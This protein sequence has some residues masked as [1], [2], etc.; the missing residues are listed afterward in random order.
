[1]SKTTVNLFQTIKEAIPT[2]IRTEF[3]LFGELLEQYYIGLE[4]KTGVYNI[5]NQIDSQIK[6]D[7][8]FSVSK[9]TKL[10]T[11]NFDF[12]TTISVESTEG[13]PERNGLIKI[14]DEIIFYK[15]KTETEFLDCYRGFSGVDSFGKSINFSET[16]AQDHAAGSTVNNLYSDLLQE[17]LFQIKKQILPGL[18]SSDIVANENIFLKQSVNFYNTKGS[19]ESFRILF[20]ALFGVSAEIIRPQENLIEPSKSYYNIT[21]DLLVEPIVGDVERCLNRTIFQESESGDLFYGT[22]TSVEKVNNLGREYYILSVDFNYDK[23]IINKGSLFGVFNYSQRTVVLEDVTVAPFISG[24]TIYVNSTLGFPNEGILQIKTPNE[25]LFDINYFGKNSNQFFVSPTEELLIPKKSYLTTKNFAFCNIEDERIQVRI[26]PLFSN[27]FSVDQN[28]LS[29]QENDPVVISSL[30]EN[31]LGDKFNNWVFNLR[32][33]ADVESISIEDDRLN[34]YRITFFNEYN[35]YLGDKFDLISSDGIFYELTLLTKNSNKVY[36]FS[37][38]NRIAN[39]TTPGFHAIR[40]ISKSKF[41]EEF[42]SS[43][44]TIANVQNIYTDLL[45]KDVYVETGSIPSYGEDNINL[46]SKRILFSGNYSTEV[47]NFTLNIGKN[48]LLTGEAVIYSESVVADLFDENGFFIGNG[49]NPNRLSIPNG[50]YFVKVVDSENIKL[51]VSLSKLFNDQFVSFS[52]SVTNNSLYYA[53]RDWLSDEFTADYIRF[54]DFLKIEHQKLIKRISE[55]VN[56]ETKVET[57]PGPIGIFKNGTELLNYK[58]LDSI[59]Y[60]SIKNIDVLTEGQEYDIINRPKLNIDDTSLGITYGSGAVGEVRLSGSLKRIEVLNPGVGFLTKPSIKISGGNGSGALA[61]PIFESNTYSADFNS[62]TSVSLATNEIIFENDSYFVTGEVVRYVSGVNTSLGGL[63]NNAS[64]FVR[65]T[66]SNKVKLYGNLEDCKR[67]INELNISSFGTGVHSLVAVKN[68]NLLVDFKVISEGSGYKSINLIFNSSAIN[69]YDDSINID[70]HQLKT[71]EIIVYNSDD[72]SLGGLS[73]GQKYYVYRVNESKI[74]LSLTEQDLNLRKF[75]NITSTGQGLHTIQYDPITVTVTNLDNNN[76]NTLNIRPIFKGFIEGVNVI[77]GG[78]EYGSR[79][80]INFNRQ[81]TISLETG[82]GCKLKPVILQGRIFAVVIENQGSGYNSVPDLQIIGDG[83]GAKILPVLNDG[84]VTDIIIQS[85]GSGYSKDTKIFVKSAGSGAEFFAQIDKWT[86]NLVEK[87]FLRRLVTDDD[88]FLSKG[89]FGLKYTYC[90]TPRKLREFTLTKRIE[91]GVERFVPDL[92]INLSDGKEENSRY[93]SPILGWAYDGNPIYGPYGF[94][95]PNGTGEIVRMKSGYNIAPKENRPGDELIF[96]L[97][98][99]V[100]DYEYSD[101]HDLDESNG[102]FCV[103]PEYPK[104][105]YA[106]FSTIGE[107]DPLYK[108]YRK[109]AFPYVIGNNYKSTPIDFNFDPNIHQDNVEVYSAL[110]KNT[111]PYNLFEENSGYEGIDVVELIQNHTSEI[112]TFSKGSVDFV[113][114]VSNGDNYKVNDRLLFDNT[115]TNS[116]GLSGFVKSLKGREIVSINQTLNSIEDVEIYK[117]RSGSVAICSSPHNIDDIGNYVYYFNEEEF[118]SVFYPDKFRLVLTENIENSST[119]GLTTYIN[120]SGLTNSYPFVFE[121]DVFELDD[122][123]LKILEVDRKASR[124]RVLRSQNGTIGVSHTAGALL[125]ERS[126]KLYSNSESSVVPF[127]R[128][129]QIYFNPVES[130]TIGNQRSTLNIVNPAFYP[131]SISI[132][133][134]QLYLRD[135]FLQTNDVLIYNSNSNFPIRVEKNSVIISLQE[136]QKLYVYRYSNDVIGLYDE[137]IYLNE[138]GEFIDSTRSSIDLF[139]FVDYGLG[140]YHSFKVSTLITTTLNQYNLRVTTDVNHSL[141][142]G[143]FVDFDFNFKDSKTIKVVY[144]L[145]N[146]RVCLNPINF[147]ES[148]VDLED[149]TIF[150]ENHGLRDFQK[151]IYNSSNP[152]ANLINDE[153]YYINVVDNNR[154]SL[155]DRDKN[156]VTIGSQSFG[157][158]LPINP[159]ISIEKNKSIVFDLSDET[160]SFV[161]NDVRYSGFKLNIYTDENRSNELN[162]TGLS[163]SFNVVRIGS[164]GISLNARLILTYDENVPSTLYYSLDPIKNDVVPNFI[165]EAVFDN[166]TSNGRIDQSTSKYA[167]TYQIVKVSNKSFKFSL[168]FIPKDELP[169]Q[170]DATYTTSS[171]NALGPVNDI[172]FN[173][174]GKDF[175]KIPYIQDIESENGKDFFGILYSSNIGNLQ[176]LNVDN[177]KYELVSDPTLVPKGLCPI[178]LKIEPLASIDQINILSFGKNYTQ[179]PDLVLVDGFTKKAVSDIV[180]EYNDQTSKVDVLKNTNGIYNVTP[181]LVPVNNTNGYRVL[182]LTYNDF[183]REATIIFDTVGFST[184]TAFPFEIGSKFLIENLI[185]TNPESDLGYNSEN[186]DY[187][188]YTVVDSDPNIGGQVPSITFS[189]SDFSGSENP[190]FFDPV[191]TSGRIIPESFFPTFDVVLKKN[192]FFENELVTSNDFEGNVLSWDKDNEFLKIRTK[193]PQLVDVGSLLFGNSS[194]SFG[195]ISDIVGVST[196]SYNLSSLRSVQKGWSDKKGFL[197]EDSQ[198]LHDSDYYQYFSYAVKSTVDNAKWDSLVQE[199]NHTAGFK[200]FSNLSVESDL[201]QEYQITPID[202][203]GGVIG[204]SNIDS[205]S[206]LN[207]FYDHDLAFENSIVVNPNKTI[208][209]EIIFNTKLLQDYFQS[210]GNRALIIDDVSGEFNSNPRSTRFSAVNEFPIGDFKY[211]KYFINSVNKF[212]PD[213]SQSIIVNL[214]QDGTNGFLNQYARVET[215][216]AQGSFDFT[217]FDNNGFLLFFPVEF[218]F[219][220]YDVTGISL[221]IGNDLVGIGSTSF[222][223]VAKIETTDTIISSGS[224]AG[225][226]IKILTQLEDYRSAKYIITV[227]TDTSGFIQS[228]EFN[229]I[230]GVSDVFYTEFGTLET[231][232]FDSAVSSGFATYYPEINGNVVDIYIVP[233]SDT[234][235]DYKVN[236]VATYLSNDNFSDTLHID[237]KTSRL[238]SSYGVILGAPATSPQ[239]I[240][241]IENTFNSFYVLASI[242]DTTEGIYEFRELVIVPSSTD[243][244]ITQFANVVSDDLDDLGTFSGVVNNLTNEILLQFEPYAPNRNIEVRMFVYA[245]KKVDLL[246]PNDSIDLDQSNIAVIFGEYI[247]TENAINRDFELKYKGLP[248]FQRLFNANDPSVVLLEENSVV[249]PNHFFNTGEKITYSHPSLSFAFPP[250]SIG[251]KTTVIAGVA[252][253]KL[254]TEVYAVKVNDTKIRLAA[255]AENALKFNPEFFELTTLGIGS[256]HKFTATRPNVKGIFTIDNVIQS[257]I[258]ETDVKV[259]L[260]TE[261]NATDIRLKLS[262]ISSISSSDILKINDE[263]VFVETVGATP[264]DFLRVRRRWLGTELQF[265]GIGS[266]VTK[267]L[268]NYNIINN[269]LSFVK[270]PFGQVPQSAPQNE[271]G[272]PFVRPDDRDF[273]GITTNSTF[274]GRVFL[275]TGEVESVEEIYEEN[276]LFDDISRDFTGITSEFVL[277]TNNSDVVGISSNNAI[278]LIKDIFQQPDRSGASPII[279]N[280]KLIEQSGQT[281]LQFNPSTQ[282]V[283]DDINVTGLP[284]GGKIISL[285]S[286]A[287]FGY[288]PLVAAGGTATISGFGSISQITIGNPGSGYRSGIQTVVNA[289]S[290]TSSSIEVVGFASILDGRVSSVTIT[291]PGTSYTNTNAPLIIFDSPLGYYDLPLIYSDQSAQGIGTGA[292]VDLVVSRNSSIFEF[293]VR[294]AGYNYR[295]GE[296]LTIDT[297]E[298]VGIPTDQ[299]KPFNEFQI[300]V[301]S[302]KN[303]EYSGWSIGDVQQLDPLDDLFDGI[304]TVFPL[305]FEGNRVSIVAKRGSN[306]DVEATLLIFINGVLQVPGR[307]YTFKGGSRIIFTEPP[308]K[309]YFSNILFYRGTK[310][311]DVRF[312]DVIE[313]IEPGDTCRLTSDL[314]ELNQ[315]K[316]QIEEVISTDIIGTT[317]YSGP[318]ITSDA[319]LLRPITICRQTEDLYLNGS[320]IPKTRSSYE[321]LIIPN[322]NILQNIDK[323]STEIFV[324]NLKTF[325]DNNVEDISNKDRSEIEIISQDN[326][327]VGVATAVVSSAGSITSVNITNPGY[328]YTVTP[329]ISISTPPE[330]SLEGIPAEVSLTISQGKITSAIVDNSGR[331]YDPNNPPYIIIES[332]KV[333]VENIINV[334][335]EGDFGIIAGIANTIVGIGSTALQMDLYIDNQ[336]FLKN[337]LVNPDISEDGTSGIGTN[338]FFVVSNSNIGLGITSLYSDGTPLSS[339][340]LYFDNIFQVYD[341]EINQKDI[342]GAGVTSVVTITTLISSQFDLTLPLF[343]NDLLTFDNTRFKFDSSSTEFSYFGNYSWGRISF[344]PERSRKNPREFNSYYQNGY[345]GISTSAAIKRVA[346]LKSRSQLNII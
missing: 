103:T 193:V 77:E 246:T 301:N 81:P 130:F 261:V 311:I 153:I 310:D 65:Q 324:E 198:R 282:E 119:T 42:S 78:S 187:R 135:H 316:R 75:I 222:G 8:I 269:T 339:T 341:L 273:T 323:N 141:N 162:Y 39:I 33:G 232:S 243:L 230:N 251:I 28:S 248:V 242:E 143:D 115:N 298:F 124:L 157:N 18:E 202:S 108:N 211:R 48:K 131:S 279:G 121:N 54:P 305:R 140:D 303:D 300:V 276:Y 73:S 288:Q 227:E 137:P 189:M 23:D 270:A 58:S 239:T 277:K 159:D 304:R 327:L 148:D 68:R 165:S 240:L 183:T 69:I 15:D 88:G 182:S 314:P 66:S 57:K 111:N 107:I 200:R 34:K 98:F 257:P 266:T 290:Q 344:D 100:E 72:V 109:P 233:N 345:A 262:G 291:N 133:P 313:P 231:T 319:T 172:E 185:T 154:I 83:T 62:S 92:T 329:Q 205:E 328:G 234:N 190:G 294:N 204:I 22:V 106:Y 338:Y 173:S 67:S 249:I 158:I 176:N 181:R 263:I 343:D 96:P 20:S 336:S 102:R 209:D 255:S 179:F 84:R 45:K 169:S 265:H 89:K 1:M 14:D 247:G 53:N 287:G 146:R 36:T 101:G 228:N 49:D 46:F 123:E 13:F 199:T 210:I 293:E 203:D 76:N 331:G 259:E 208:S 2:F 79:E 24:S 238:L 59:F 292:R 156:F 25:E 51:A 215:I 325:F 38:N 171:K 50:K 245:L 297:S 27:D 31:N 219:N 117:Y 138:F 116:F 74:K 134:G 212:F 330:S 299:S 174:K 104:G 307:S 136:N 63:T 312:V 177:I 150:I 12:E 184:I 160:L 114:I 180:I 224:T 5:L 191:F 342:I 64:Y 166:E 221:N 283:N 194:N 271:L 21:T 286:T 82:S 332:P 285:G 241:T 167:N 274:S 244:Y 306:I 16:S 47:D 264:S 90:Y 322:T 218:E 17:F 112:K 229:V 223:N 275:R 317:P 252:T 29:L 80:I 161:K 201:E 236:I 145:S 192:I 175:T 127:S 289:Y 44:Q 85:A 308:Q 149:N 3:P 237:L 129:R 178:S 334:Q 195:T 118:R 6:L 35:F 188:L 302:V 260:T 254:P 226:P 321:P 278:I 40:K 60:G 340:N 126:R 326:V 10:L 296:I 216:Q 280:Y 30:G 320:L 337:S 346:K 105:I 163:N 37:A 19:K 144:N 309:E 284:V 256:E 95:N 318:G 11:E 217:V 41:N 61:S 125:E 9:N 281:I 315:D 214:I 97:G 267:L 220:D 122:E 70:N 86:I 113:S 7:E 333:D 235:E 147:S 186:Y 213:D 258:I 110:L 268:G 87:N 335:Y 152:S 55:P 71:G 253:D 168:D 164:V 207:C 225:V 32:N 170:Y 94:S 4:K 93:H 272:A 196:V 52:G 26:C 155:L 197:N 99:F 139:K 206:D 295:E 120:V 142:T 250:D 56:A 132:D 43:F 91:S 128:Q 151:I